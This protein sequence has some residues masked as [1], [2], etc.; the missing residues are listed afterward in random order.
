M[1]LTFDLTKTSISP[2]SS[3]LGDVSVCYFTNW[4]QYRGGAAR[5]TVNNID[6]SLC[7]HLVYAF[8]R[9]DPDTLSLA[10]V[11]SNDDT[12]GGM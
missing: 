5:Y 8:A 10:P 2:L 9:V 4:S 11:E 7:T 3:A 6:P 12:P 1:S